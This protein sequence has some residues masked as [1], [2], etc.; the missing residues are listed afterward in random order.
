MSRAIKQ[1]YTIGGEDITVYRID[2]DYYGNP[3]Y[4]AHFLSLGLPDYK[5]RTIANRLGWSVY[6]GRWFGGGLV[7]QSYNIERDLEQIIT[8]YQEA[9]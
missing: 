6:R 3:R 5:D 2:N 7:T 9:N 8:A 1:T 4:V